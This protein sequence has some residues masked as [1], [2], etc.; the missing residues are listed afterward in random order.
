MGGPETECLKWRA[1]GCCQQGQGVRG[2]AEAG[3]E[4][5]AVDS[6]VAASEGITEG[7]CSSP[8][9]GSDSSWAVLARGTR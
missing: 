8:G 5:A 3:E 6:A 4:V 7:A 2:A 9:P 1:A